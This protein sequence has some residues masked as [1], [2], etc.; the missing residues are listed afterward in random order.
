[1]LF[2]QAIC[3]HSH[4]IE[5]MSAAAGFKANQPMSGV[6]CVNMRRYLRAGGQPV[7]KPQ[8]ATLLVEISHGPLLYLAEFAK[9][10]MR[11]RAFSFSSF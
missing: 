11:V 2:D 8:T 9:E 1:M 3:K 4:L 6:R 5:R 10:I 7:N